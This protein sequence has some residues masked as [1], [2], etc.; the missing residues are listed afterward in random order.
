MVRDHE[1]R[2]DRILDAAGELLL[3]FGYRKV[4]IEDIARRAGIGKG[5]VYLHWRTKQEL[6]DALLRRQSI[7]LIVALLERLRADPAEVMPHRMSSSGFLICLDDPLVMALVTGDAELLGQ[8]RDSPHAG[9]DL[10]AADQIHDIWARHGLIRTDMPNLRYA[11]TAVSTGFYLIDDT[12]ESA[13]ID[14]RAK[15]D[16]MAHALRATFEPATR[17]NTDALAA[18]AA[19]VAAICEDVIDSYRKQLYSDDGEDE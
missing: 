8:L 19:E 17:P 7:A 18:A 4:T 6:F 2:T 5:T 12:P 14:A 15:A 3:R 10:I 11:M 1:R 9:Q 16:S 13:G